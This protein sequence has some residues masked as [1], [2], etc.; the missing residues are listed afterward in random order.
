M[1]FKGSQFERDIILW[2][3]RWYVAYPIS[4]RQPEEMMQERGVEVD[5]SSLNRWVLKYTPA[6]DKAFRQRKRAVG[7][8]WRLDET[9]MC[10]TKSLWKLFPLQ[11]REPPVSPGESRNLNKE[12]F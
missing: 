8:S 12:R 10:D 5:H 3:V 2:G 4:Y 1:D 11:W 9:Y 6:L 7:T